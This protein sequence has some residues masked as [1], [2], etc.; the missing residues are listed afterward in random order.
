MHVRLLT[1]LLIC[2]HLETTAQEKIY[3][4]EGWQVTSR[5]NA[6]WYRLYTSENGLYKIEDHYADGPLYM[7]GYRSTVASNSCRYREGAITF[8]D[9][10]GHKLR[11]GQYKAG[12]RVGVWKF[13]YAGSEAVNFELRYLDDTSETAN[14]YVFDS[15]THE[16][17]NKSNYPATMV[18]TEKM[19][20]SGFDLNQY[21]AQN[22]RYPKFARSANIEGRVIVRFVV[23]EDGAI[24]NV[25]VIKGI[26]GGCDQEAIRV[27]SEMQYG[28]PVRVYF[29][30]PINFKLR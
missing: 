5:K 18:Y 23:D 7:T 29:T 24:S 6:E 25:K 12:T 16:L 2:I 17:T 27:V 30:L 1:L 10:T 3:Y 26:G 8:Y 9:K 4:D 11:E 21:I 20:V 15:A 19:P 28:S 13:Y 22:M 14:T